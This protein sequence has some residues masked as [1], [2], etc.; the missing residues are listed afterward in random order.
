MNRSHVKQT[1]PGHHWPRSFSLARG[2]VL[3][4]LVLAGMSALRA[5]ENT[6]APAPSRTSHK[7]S[8]YSSKQGVVRQYSQEDRIRYQ[9]WN[10]VWK[11]DPTQPIT[12]VEV[13]I[14]EQKVYVYQGD[15]VGGESPVTSRTFTGSFWTPTG[16]SSTAMR[17]S[18]K[19]RR[20]GPFTIRRTC[21]TTCASATTAWVSTQ[22]ICPA[23]RPRTAAFGCRTPSPNC[24]SRI[25]PSA[26]RLMLC[27]ETSSQGRVLT[28]ARKGKGVAEYF[29]GITE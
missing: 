21:P 29:D 4:M 18:V 19:R 5:D 11:P 6:G 27:P 14:G 7:E 28:I 22:G 10:Y 13:R 2:I 12:R 24:F 15:D 3:T 26:R 17:R 20:R 1:A 23:I 25:S 16:M 9:L 8:V